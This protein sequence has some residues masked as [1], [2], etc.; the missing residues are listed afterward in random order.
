[1]LH[2]WR[3]SAAASLNG[4][5]GSVDGKQG[6]PKAPVTADISANMSMI[7]FTTRLRATCSQ[8][9]DLLSGYFHT[10]PAEECVYVQCLANLV[11]HCRSQWRGGGHVLQ[12]PFIVLLPLYLLMCADEYTRTALCAT[13]TSQ[14]ILCFGLSLFFRGGTGSNILC[15]GMVLSIFLRP[16]LQLVTRI[17]TNQ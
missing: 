14:Y 10:V 9:F 6:A 8:A 12:L 1:M 17:C 2:A 7:Q 3:A 11:S 13:H 15:F 5:L 4:K 16:Q